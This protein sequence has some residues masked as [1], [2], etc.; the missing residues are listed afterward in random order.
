MTSRAG[1]GFAIVLSVAS[2]TR[3]ALAQPA[4]STT[5]TGSVGLGFR[6]AG[7]VGS[8]C[9]PVVASDLEHP[10]SI[11]FGGSVAHWLT[12]RAAVQAEA[13]W[14]G[15]AAYGAS[16]Q[17]QVGGKPCVACSSANQVSTV[18]VAGLVRVRGARSRRAAFDIVAGGGWAAELARSDVFGV[19]QSPEEFMP[20]RVHHTHNRGTFIA[21]ADLT[22]PA[23]HPRVAVIA[24]FRL[25]QLL[26][27]PDPARTAPA[28]GNTVWRAAVGLQ[29]SFGGRA[30]AADA[31]PGAGSRSAPHRF[32]D[33]LNISLTAAEAAALLA[34]G[35][36]TQIAFSR[37]SF[38]GER[39]PIA[40]PFVSRGWP[41]QIAGGAIFVAAD[42]GLR[43]LL[44]GKRHHLAERLL[45]LA[46]IAYGTVCATHNA[47]RL[48]QLD[49]MGVPTIR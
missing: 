18:T 10:V 36:T 35:L 25:Q 29:G 7:G 11:G 42:V 32:F 44:H 4:G 27:D 46:L 43:Y 15:E 6:G 47:V 14:F 30:P 38:L 17:G 41:G 37:Y 28:L 1:I 24:S 22:T 48:H 12:D 8:C 2:F 31:A 40:R 21:G 9:G 23:F 5:L 26:G 16:V 45:P 3:P 39:D 13:S 19:P 34:D 20:V 49:A 33:R